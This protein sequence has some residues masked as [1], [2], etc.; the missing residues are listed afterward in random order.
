MLRDIRLIS[1]LWVLKESFYEHLGKKIKAQNYI[2]SLMNSTKHFKKN[3][4]QFYSNSS[5]KQKRALTKIFYEAKIVL[6]PKFDKDITITYKS[7][8]H[9]TIE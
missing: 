8:F 4:H 1:R 9:I 6:I 3:S 5:K 2:A 7:I